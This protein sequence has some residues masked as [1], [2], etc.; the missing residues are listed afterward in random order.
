MTSFLSALGAKLAEKWV[1][2]LLLPGLLF[3]SLCA[4]G[5]QLGHAHAW[6]VTRL[7]G[8]LNALAD[9]PAAGMP[10]TVALTA[11][12]VLAAST[13]AGLLAAAMA[14]WV[15]RAWLGNWPWLLTLSF[16]ERMTQRR[17]RR[18][19]AADRRFREER[20]RLVREDQEAEQQVTILLDAL[21][22]GPTDPGGGPEAAPDHSLTG[23]IAKVAARYET[24][25]RIALTRP[26]HPTWM[27]DRMAAAE[28]RIRRAYALD[29]PT[30]WPRLWLLLPEAPRL[31]LHSARADLAAAGRRAAWGVLCL[32]LA[33]WWWPAV[34]AA[35]VTGGSA[36]RQGRQA[37][38]AFA[39][40][41][42][43]AVDVHG[44]ELVRALGADVEAELSRKSGAQVTRI[45]RKDD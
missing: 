18:W 28:S 36:W 1:S 11:V 17:V 35:L 45:V 9:E 13:G 41:V 31:D 42:E 25:N 20:L 21:G 12:L 38:D 7:V 32:V 44:R 24:R 27:G 37:V 29:L 6:D 5:A 4:V 30:V 22:L 23:G 19:E 34:V 33:V 26:I 15:E 3:V 40:L 43:S 8:H 16:G 14:A 10:G 2:L 39:V